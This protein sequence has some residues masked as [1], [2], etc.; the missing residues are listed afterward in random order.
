MA[1][2]FYSIYPP[3][4]GGVN[5]NPSVAPN[6]QNPS[7]TSSTLV[8]GQNPS[9]A[10]QPLQTDSSGN[11][12]V[13]IVSP[14]NV[15]ENLAQV[16]GVTVV[17][18]SPGVQ[19]VGVVGSTGAALDS[20]AGTANAIALT[21]QGNASGIAVPISAVAL[22]LPTG[23][24]TSVN[25]VNEIANLNTIAVNTA[26]LLDTVNVA[27]QGN[28]AVVVQAP[29]PDSLGSGNLTAA[30]QTISLTTYGVG[31]AQISITGTWSGSIQIQGSANGGASP[32]NLQ[33]LQS[34]VWTLSP[35]TANGV[36]KIAGI[37]SYNN[38]QAIMITHVSGSAA[39]QM[40]GSVANDNIQIIQANAANLNATV[41]GNSAAGSGS[42]T[43]LVTVQGN[44]SGTPIPV[45][46]TVT[47]TPS[48]EQNVNLN[49]VGGSTI[50][51]G[52][53]L[54][55]ASLP[56]VLPAAQITTLTPPTT[57]TVQQPTGTNLNAVVAQATAASLNA[58]VVGNTAAGSGASS[59]LITVQGNASGTPI[60]TTQ[61]RSDVA[62]ATQ[63]ITVVDSGSTTTAGANSQ[64]IITGT[65]TAGSTASFALSAAQSV[66][67]QVTGTWTGT[68]ESEISFDGGTTWYTRGIKQAGV[69][70]IAST[71][72]ANLQGGANTA[73]VTNYRV[74]AIAAMTGT[75]VIRVIE[76]LNTSAVLVS[77]PL[78]LKDSTT[79]SIGNTIKAASTA[80]VAADT[81]FVVALSPNSNSVKSAGL[82]VAN[83]PVYNVYSTTN[84]TTTAYVQLVAS[85]TLATNYVDI[86]DSSG[87]A[88]ILAVGAP[89]SEVIQAYI[90]PGGDE[91]SLAIPAGSRIAYKALTGNATTGYLLLNVRN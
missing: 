17:S 23:A 21:I 76:S 29:T 45:T 78:M 25:Q 51:I 6:G 82:S 44:A 19:E 3:I 52:Q 69:A 59:G 88:M 34:G 33:T 70:Y 63:N 40:E 71:W 11:L 49:Q 26:V 77:N 79:Q 7:A 37:A 30:T 35:I 43:G 41:I 42:A 85:T 27:V 14:V 39:V 28:A 53:Q 74:R 83:A 10:Q 1:G 65:P 62:P 89:G 15:S 68:L 46:G 8:A 87:Q 36:Y 67:V 4:S 13:D 84:I 18:A 47:V 80:A 9:G 60:P 2:N 66:E 32:V 56:V 75:A 31:A 73:G 58:T 86:F 57:V 81:A 55:A 50:S 24:A 61:L 16:G 48:G 12:K 90:P 5:S 64:T 54:S 22:P 91:F 72:T 20:A 38:I